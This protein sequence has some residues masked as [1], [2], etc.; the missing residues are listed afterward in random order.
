MDENQQDIITKLKF[1]GKIGKGEKINV[2]ELTLQS[3]GILTKA[4]RTLWYTDNR[5]NAQSFIQTTIQAGFSLINNLTKNNSNGAIQLINNIL[6]DIRQ[7][8]I[9]IT[10]LKTTYSDDTFF[11]CSIDTYVETLSAKLID[12]ETAHSNIIVPNMDDNTDIVFQFPMA[13]NNVPYFNNSDEDNQ[14]SN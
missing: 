3:E 8:K 1:L 2:K 5:N 7:A 9:G 10:N 6:N 13:D 4:S 14:N 11:C 12:F